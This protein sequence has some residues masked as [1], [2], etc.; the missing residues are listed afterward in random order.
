MST[1]PV[2][3][4]APETGWI[5][6]DGVTDTDLNAI[7]ENLDAIETGSRTLSPTTPTGLSAGLRTLL[8]WFAGQCLRLSGKTNWY[9]APAWNPETL[10]VLSGGVGCISNLG[11]LDTRGLAAAAETA[12][13]QQIAV[14]VPVGFSLIL[15]RIG[16]WI[17][18]DSTV[19]MHL[20]V[21]ATLHTARLWES[22]LP[23]GEAT[24]DHVL[25]SND[26]TCPAYTGSALLCGVRASYYNAGVITHNFYTGGGWSGMLELVN[27]ENPYTTTT[28]TAAP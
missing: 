20:R 22:A 6:D 14:S 23:W 2:G 28:T 4:T 10:R 18:G 16:H 1:A 17:L 21:A 8:D 13:L 9:D 25:I 12:A 27:E 15:R 24:P 11:V 19:D 7:G 5:P 3:W 26:P